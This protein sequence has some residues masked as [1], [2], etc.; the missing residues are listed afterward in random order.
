MTDDTAASL[1]YAFVV[2]YLDY[3]N[4]LLADV[5][6]FYLDP[7]ILKQYCSGCSEPSILFSFFFIIGYSLVPSS[8]QSQLVL[9]FRVL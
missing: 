9:V 3:W 8:N 6:Y 7:L 5:P 1:V 2:S 4:S